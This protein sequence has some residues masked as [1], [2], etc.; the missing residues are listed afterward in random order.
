MRSALTL[1]LCLIAQGCARGTS[2]QTSAG[3]GAVPAGGFSSANPFAQ[4]SSLP[5]QAPAFNH[6]RNADYQPAIEEGMRRQRAE[7]DSIARQQ[8]PPTFE[9]TIVALERTGDLLNRTLRVFE[10]VV[11]ANTNDTLQ[12][13]QTEEAPK[14]AALSDARYLDSR[15]FQRVHSVYQGRATLH[16]SPEQNTLVERYHLNF[17]R[18]GAQL[19][20]SAKDRLRQ[21][22]Q[23]EARLS[24][25]FENTLLAAA[26]AGALVL[27][28]RSLLKGLSEA[29][30]AASAEAAK[31]RG[32]TGK[33]LIALQ[34]TTQQPA[35]ASLENRSVRQRLFEASIHRADRGDSN[36]TRAIVRRLAALRI[37]RANLLGVPTFADYALANQ[38]AKTPEAA[39]SL[40][41]QLVPPATRKARAEAAKM[42]ALIDAQKGGFRLAPWDWQYYA[43]RVRQ[44]EYNLDESQLKP[45]LSL[46]RVLQDG[47]FYAATQLYGITFKERKDLPVYHPDVRVFEVFDRDGTPMALFYADYFKRDNKGGGAWMDTFVD[48]SGLRGTKPVVYNVANFTKPA[49]GMPALLTFEDVTTMF[50]EFG[51]ALHGLFAHV[52]YPL[53]LN[54]PRDFVEFPSQFNEHWALEPD[55]FARYARH[56]QTGAP[57]PQDLVER[58]KKSSTFNQGYATT[59]YLAAALLD[60]AWHTLPRGTPEQDVATFE[61]QALERYHV[62]LPEIPPRYRTPYFEHIWAGGYS[63]AYYAY[64]W[65]EV[66]DHDAYAWFVEHGGLSRE[67]GQ[68]YRDMI[69][70]RG[71]T[72]DLGALYRAFRGRDPSIK[73]LLQQRGLDEPPDEQ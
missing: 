12:R 66:L 22:N 62:D 60:L 38:M 57:M 68:R 1:T 2:D 46:D 56:Y 30:V 45:Y 3:A 23:E 52:Q 20:E 40:V 43:E 63:A 53:L 42:Q 70:S 69:L 28:D 10:A 9:N 7:L 16:L 47:V 58:I 61:R 49:P 14:L 55:V 4:P 18:A 29:E 6:I 26:K 11:Q 59:E 50:H 19:P 15:L 21:L 39:I 13:V 65:S 41:S 8:A 36:D 35:L 5:Y 67:N 64:L 72:E 32:L 54:T 34:N 17:V 44:A 51:H 31:E 48:P 25:S 73:P 24:T 27:D 37:E 71:S 33:Y